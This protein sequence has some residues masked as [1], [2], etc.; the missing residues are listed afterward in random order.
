MGRHRHTVTGVVVTVDDSKDARYAGG[1]WE[2]GDTPAP[3]PKK[4]AAK[5]TASKPVK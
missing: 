1:L 5:K 3:A 2:P 4:S